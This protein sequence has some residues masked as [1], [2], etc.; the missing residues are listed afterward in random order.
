[1]DAMERFE[2]LQD[3][4][5]FELAIALMAHRLPE[6]FFETLTI[7][8]WINVLEIIPKESEQ[9][10]IVICMMRKVFKLHHWI[11]LLKSPNICYEIKE[12]AEN[13][14]LSVLP[15]SEISLQGLVGIWKEL[16]GI[17]HVNVLSAVITEKII[18]TAKDFDDWL[19]ISDNIPKE[20]DSS[21]RKT[22]N[23]WWLLW[24]KAKK[25]KASFPCNSKLLETAE[26]FE[27]WYLVWKESSTLN[28]EIAFEKM[29]EILEQEKQ[30]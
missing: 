5:G 8:D 24:S 2:K 26:T 20:I 3:K 23:N 22:I 12:F 7:Q 30:G 18:N 9:K 21:F 28:K 25:E 11:E 16:M 14:F 6:S 13:G 29:Q 19:Y 10:K 4:V 15:Q 17:I 1:M 27:Q